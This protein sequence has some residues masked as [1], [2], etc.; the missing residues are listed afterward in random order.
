MNGCEFKNPV[1]TATEYL[2]A[3]QYGG[4]KVSSAI[5]RPPLRRIG[6]KG[7]GEQAN[8]VSRT[9]TFPY[10][11]WLLRDLERPALGCKV[12]RRAKFFSALAPFLLHAFLKTRGITRT[13]IS[14]RSRTDCTSVCLVIILKNDDEFSLEQATKAQRG[15]RCIALLFLQPRR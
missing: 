11:Y 5:T 10:E 14:R 3:C 9:R 8:D 15:N 12:G 4:D 13:Q 2:H 7:T 6:C 1:S